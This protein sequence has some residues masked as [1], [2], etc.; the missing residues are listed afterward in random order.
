MRSDF[1]TSQENALAQFQIVARASCPCWLEIFHG[2]DAH[3]TKR[4]LQN[5]IGRDGSPSRPRTF[6]RNVPTRNRECMGFARASL[7]MCPLIFRRTVRSR[8]RFTVHSS[9]F[10]VL[11]SQFMVFQPSFTLSPYS[12]RIQAD[13]R[14]N[15]PSC[16]ALSPT[17][18]GLVQ[19]RVANYSTVNR[20]L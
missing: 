19:N 15:L 10:T 18:N 4:L 7:R 5:P 2:R 1:P 6:R 16:L 3:A 11:S 17:F 8:S 9:Q 14:Q 12:S 20:E 13:I